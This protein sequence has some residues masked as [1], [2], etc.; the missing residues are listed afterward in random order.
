VETS[1]EI[2]AF[3]SEPDKRERRT[4]A[5]RRMLGEA[6]VEGNTVIVGHQASLRAA[7]GLALDEGEAI[8]FRPGVKGIMIGRV[9]PREWTALLAAL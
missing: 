9:K 2:A 3:L 5:L 1:E 4:L 6:P 7:A 8:V